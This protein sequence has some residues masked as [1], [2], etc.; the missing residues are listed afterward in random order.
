MTTA[1]KTKAAT[2][3]I[4]CSDEDYFDQKYYKFTNNNNVLVITGESSSGCPV[5][6]ISSLWTTLEEHQVILGIILFLL[7]FQLLFYGLLMINVTVFIAGYFVSFAIYGGIFTVFLGPDS[8]SIAVYFSLLFILLAS[9]LTA[10]G[11]TKLIN[12]SI[13]FIGA[14]KN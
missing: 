11:L 3:R 2:F 1:D 5:F 9:T 8:T 14:C 6:Q 13:F 7:G 12:V 10:Y 4:F